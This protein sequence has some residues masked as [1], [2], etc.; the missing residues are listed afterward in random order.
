MRAPDGSWWRPVATVL[1]A[2]ASARE[3]AA[4]AAGRLV[5]DGA[6]RPG[7][8]MMLWARFTTEHYL[9]ECERVVRIGNDWTIWAAC[10]ERPFWW[11]PVLSWEDAWREAAEAGRPLQQRGGEH[12]RVMLEL[13]VHETPN[14][15]RRDELHDAYDAA[16]Q[17]ERAIRLRQ[18]AA[19]VRERAGDDVFEL[20]IAARDERPERRVMVPRAPFW[21][22][23]LGRTNLLHFAPPWDPISP[24]GLKLQLDDPYHSDWM[25]GAGLDLYDDYSASGSGPVDEAAMNARLELQMKLGGYDVVVL[26]DGGAVTGVVGQDIA[27]LPDLSVDYKDAALTSRAIIAERGGALAHL[28]IVGMERGLTVV[29]DPGALIRYP[30]GSVLTINPEAGTVRIH[31]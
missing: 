16:M 15:E 29:R 7:Q 27:V 6:L 21:H 17:E 1:N 10:G 12:P 3:A 2:S 5:D 26:S 4:H 23:A 30:K 14:Q 31:P 11:D 18:I 28:A 25:L 8:A 24:V 13:L 19:E 20:V 9:G 22:W